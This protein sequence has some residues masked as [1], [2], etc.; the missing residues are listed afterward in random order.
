MKEISVTINTDRLYKE[1]DA[2][3]FKRVDASMVEQPDRSQNAVSSDRE[4]S[5]DKGVMNCYIQDREATLRLRLAFCLK[6]EETSSVD[7]SIKSS[8]SYTLLVP[9][10]FPDV[11]AAGI[12]EKM[13]QYILR[14]TLHDWYTGQG[15]SNP[16]SEDGLGEMLKSIVGVLRSGSV[17]RPLQP[18]GPRN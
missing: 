17:K 4:E 10:A 7:N 16:Y 9:D 8:Y 3:T 1:I 12:V 11:V 15:I 6:V 14:G 13:H 2:I 5:L 18:F